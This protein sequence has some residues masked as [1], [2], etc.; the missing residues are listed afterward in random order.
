MPAGMEGVVNSGS[1]KV[2][3]HKPIKETDPEILCQRARNTIL[4]TLK[5]RG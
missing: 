2:I 5:H 1:V 4:A 3:I